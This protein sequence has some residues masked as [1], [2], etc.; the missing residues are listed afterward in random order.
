MCLKLKEGETMTN[1]SEKE[2][3]LLNFAATFSGGDIF[4]GELG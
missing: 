1:E 3:K 2:Q 4:C